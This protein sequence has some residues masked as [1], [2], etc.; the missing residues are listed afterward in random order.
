MQVRLPLTL[1]PRDAGNKL[2]GPAYTIIGHDAIRSMHVF[3]F[4]VSFACN[5]AFYIRDFPI[6]L[7]A[8]KIVTHVT[9]VHLQARMTEILDE[10]GWEDGES[11]KMLCRRSKGKAQNLH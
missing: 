9:K 1:Y 3:A 6:S 11:G 4:G 10:L 8:C 7:M 5:S 2:Y